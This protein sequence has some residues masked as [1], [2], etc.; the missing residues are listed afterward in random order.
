[1]KETKKSR[2]VIRAIFDNIDQLTSEHIKSSQTLIE[3]IK[4]EAPKAIEDAI[5]NKK[6]YASIFEINTTNNY[7]DIHRRYWIDTL[8]TC[9]QW[10][11]QDE[12]E[13]YETCSHI[14][15]LIETLKK[16]KRTNTK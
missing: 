16:S 4:I 13:D 3:L 14:S 12:L 7:I 11:L 2:R 8:N 5:V 1:M 15:K 6:V 10:H 9:L